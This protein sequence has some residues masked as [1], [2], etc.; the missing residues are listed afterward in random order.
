MHY[1]HDTL[2]GAMSDCFLRCKARKSSLVEPSPPHSSWRLVAS[3]SKA[4]RHRQ[5]PIACLWNALTILT[6]PPL[7]HVPGVAMLA[8]LLA[9]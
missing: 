5:R 8:G 1:R 4:F 6:L 9:R 7:S 2:E 3:A